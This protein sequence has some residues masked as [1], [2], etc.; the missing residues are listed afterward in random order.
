MTQKHPIRDVTA[1]AEFAVERTVGAVSSDVGLERRAVVKLLF[2]EEA[3]EVSVAQVV[4]LTHV[5]A[6]L[7]KITEGQLAVLAGVV[8]VRISLLGC[9]S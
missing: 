6:V 9:D 3:G 4:H 1:R 5:V 2:A 7:G 8:G